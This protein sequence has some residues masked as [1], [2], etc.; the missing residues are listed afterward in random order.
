M[1]SPASRRLERKPPSPDRSRAGAWCLVAQ[2]QAAGS[3]KPPRPFASRSRVPRRP[4]R[5]PAASTM[6]TSCLVCE[7]SCFSTIS[8]CL[9]CQQTGL[10][11]WSTRLKARTSRVRGA[12]PVTV[13]FGE[14]GVEDDI[15]ADHHETASMTEVAKTVDEL[16][17]RMTATTFAA[18][19]DVF[20]SI[21]ALV[22]PARSLPRLHR[23]AR[24]SVLQYIANALAPCIED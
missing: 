20:R 22:K 3:S 24:R 21:V 17:S 1:F 19:L 23:G 8:I 13:G 10:R 9:K 16:E 12:P 15:A 4:G 5:I 7:T 6:P 2:L 14:L 11:A 18:L